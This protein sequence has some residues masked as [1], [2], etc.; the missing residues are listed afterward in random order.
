MTA[1]LYRIGLVIRLG[2]PRIALMVGITAFAGAV[3]GLVK[4]SGRDVHDVLLITLLTILT[5]YGSAVINNYLDRD[6]DILMHRT[7]RRPLV[8]GEFSPG[9][10]FWLGVSTV[11]FAVISM[12]SIYGFLPAFLAFSAFVSYSL[13]YTLYLKRSTPWASVIGALPGAMP[14]LIGYSAMTGSLD[15]EA[16]LLFLILVIWQ[17]P[18]FWYLA[19]MLEGDYRRAGIPVLPV[20]YGRNFPRNLTLIFSLLMVLGLLLPCAFGMAGRGYCYGIA[21]A[22]VIWIAVSLLAFMGKVSSRVAFVLSN[23]VVLL[24][25]ILFTFEVVHSL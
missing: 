12:L 16:I 3:T 13:V 4:G 23:L 8:S 17:P 22:S 1:I 7:R 11:A 5:A 6:I 2:K 20:V 19:I 14:P 18:H 10:A 9:R 15:M 24:A 21:I 25:F